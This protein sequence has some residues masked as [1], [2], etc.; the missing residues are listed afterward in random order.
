MRTAFF[1]VAMRLFS[2]QGCAAARMHWICFELCHIVT[3][4]LAFSF[5]VC[6][7]YKMSVEELQQEVKQLRS[8][9]EELRTRAPK[10]GPVRQKIEQM[11]AEVVDANPYRYDHTWPFDHN[12]KVILFPQ[13]V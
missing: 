2:Q 3:L 9:V 6:A 5:T 13:V 7:L 8:L 1:V 11:S 12:N 4:E 10:D